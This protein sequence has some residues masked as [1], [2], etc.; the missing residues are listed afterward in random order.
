MTFAELDAIKREKINY[1][2]STF[3]IVSKSQNFCDDQINIHFAIND[4]W[5]DIDTLSHYRYTSIGLAIF[6]RGRKL[7]W[8]KREPWQTFSK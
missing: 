7:P 5:I 8:Q 3:L 1:I 4:V 6:I 2:I